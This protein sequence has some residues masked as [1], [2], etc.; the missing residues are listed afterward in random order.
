MR[1]SGHLGQ[2]LFI[3]LVS[4]SSVGFGQSGF[5]QLFGD[6]LAHDG[7]GVV[8]TPTGWDVAVRAYGG[9]GIGYRTT[10]F[11]RTASGL[12]D[13]QVIWDLP[14]NTFVHA[15]APVGNGSYICGSTLPPGRGHKALVA[16]MDEQGDLLWFR[17]L[18][19]QGS[20]QFLGLT[21]L[22]DG[23]VALCGMVATNQGHDVLV[24][25]YSDNGDLLWSAV[26]PFDLDAE[27]YGIATDGNGIMVTGRRSNFGGGTDAL[28][29]YY[30]LD[31]SL[32]MSTSWGGIAND[33]GRALTATS[34]GNFVMAGSTSSY[35][36]VDAQG[37]RRINLHLIKIT[38]GGDTI[39]TRTQG[40]IVW[41]REAFAIAVAPNGDLLV[42]G[43]KCGYGAQHNTSDALMARFTAE[44]T[45]IWERELDVARN[46]GLR[47]IVALADGFVAAGWTFGAEGRHALLLRRDANGN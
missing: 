21:G 44:G 3:A 14:T 23:G 41:D 39:W 18:P 40:D 37:T 5:T 35:G 25:R 9:V 46:D 47:S 22:S 6:Q 20:Q 27:G 17:E 28:F 15:M 2:L 31:G 10:V 43:T 26:E 19:G 8:P 29:L 34:D 12:E 33:E 36:P 11:R 4:A 30:D 24:A 38:A 1:W 13:E 16:R 42:A 32:Q 7:I 45:A